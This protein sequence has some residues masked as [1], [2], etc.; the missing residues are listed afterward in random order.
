MLDKWHKK[1]K[2]LQGLAGMGGGIV[3]RLMGGLVLS[4][5][6]FNV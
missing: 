6:T 3:S 2:P 1:E 5:I 4:D